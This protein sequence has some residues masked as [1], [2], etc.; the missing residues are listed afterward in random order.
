MISSFARRVEGRGGRVPG[1]FKVV[2]WNVY[3]IL[4]RRFSLTLECPETISGVLH[5][6]VHEVKPVRSQVSAGAANQYSVSSIDFFQLVQIDRNSRSSAYPCDPFISSAT[7]TCVCKSSGVSV[8]NAYLTWAV[9]VDYCRIEG[10]PVPM[11]RLSRA[12]G[13]GHP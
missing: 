7:S 9:P 5:H 6:R 11:Q 2:N 12:T 10:H 1:I 3:N 13:P 8:G 4:P